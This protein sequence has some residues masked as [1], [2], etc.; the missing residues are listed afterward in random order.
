MRDYLAKS[1]RIADKDNRA[2]TSAAS[3]VP[4]T[5]KVTLECELC[6]SRRINCRVPKS[7][8]WERVDLSTLC[9]AGCLR[10]ELAC[11]PA[12]AAKA[13]GS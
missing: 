13:H 11:L 3:D 7:Q 12:V 2:E 9:W 1:V 10:T 6:H 5:A 4:G 8:I